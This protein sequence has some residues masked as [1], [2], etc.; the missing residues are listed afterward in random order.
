MSYLTPQEEQKG[1]RDS[2]K[3]SV[4]LTSTTNVNLGVN[5]TVLDGVNLVDED[6]VLLKKQTNQRENGLYTWDSITRR[7]TRSRDGLSFGSGMVVTV[8]EGDTFADSQWQLVTED[9]EVGPD[10]LVFERS[11]G[12]GAIITQ[13]QMFV[14]GHDEVDGLTSLKISSQ[15]PFNPGDWPPGKQFFFGGVLSVND[16]LRTGSLE[17]HNLDDVDQV[18]TGTLSTSS[19]TP[20]KVESSALTVGGA[21]GNLRNT[22]TMYEARILND[23][24][25]NIEKT[26]LGCIYIRIAD[27]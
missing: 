15:F 20:V 5:I 25:V 2:Y 22:E 16:V 18:T 7:F 26:I 14:V 8:R 24:T 21:A 13:L 17:L 1:I 10:N 6:R 11:A 19:L 3:P 23:G 9:P 12:K 4:R 27:A